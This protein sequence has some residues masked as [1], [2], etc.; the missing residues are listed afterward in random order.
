M[1]VK[2]W[3][4]YLVLERKLNSIFS[5]FLE[6][7]DSDGKEKKPKTKEKEKKKEVSSMF[8]ISGQKEAKGKKKGFTF[9]YRI[10]TSNQIPPLVFLC[11]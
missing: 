2:V 7:K 8:Q 6:D 3:L 5:L 4:W 9:S 10:W 11:I 1:D